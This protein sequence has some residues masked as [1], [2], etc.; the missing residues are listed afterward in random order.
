MSSVLNC[1]VLSAL[2][3]FEVYITKT[4]FCLFTVSLSFWSMFPA[5]CFVFFLKFFWRTQVLF[6]GSLI[7]CFGLL[8][9]S[10]LSFKARVDTSLP[11]FLACMQWIPQIHLWCNTCQ[12]LDGQC[13]SR[14]HS[15]TEVGCQGSEE[16]SRTVGC[17]GSDGLGPPAQ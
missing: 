10:T 9:T 15:L 12:P 6:V 14:L 4:H 5:L 8:V 2:S 13:D 3:L 17:Q 11:C 7:P 16:T 1:S